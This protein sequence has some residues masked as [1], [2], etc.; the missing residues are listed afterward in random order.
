MKTMT[1]VTLE[2]GPPWKMELLRDVLAEHGV[3]ALVVD[4]NIKTI[5]PFITG[6]LAFDARLEVEEEALGDA[7]AALAS[8]RAEGE[9]LLPA[10]EAEAERSPDATIEALEDLG[11][12]IRWSAIL[13]WMHPFLFLYGWRY[14]GALPRARRTPAGHGLTLLALGCVTVFWV[15]LLAGLVRILRAAS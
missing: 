4:T 14:L 12:R 11:R 8:A 7:R 15:V 5:D 1:R 3:D 9:A 10:D 2:M 6:S 13:F